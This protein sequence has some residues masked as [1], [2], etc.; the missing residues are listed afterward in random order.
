MYLGLLPPSHAWAEGQKEAH[1]LVPHLEPEEGPEEHRIVA[2]M[3]H[4]LGEVLG[5]H[6]T[7]LRLYLVAVPEEQSIAAMKTD[8]VVVLEVAQSLR[9]V[10]YPE[11]VLEALNSWILQPIGLDRSGGCICS[12]SHRPGFGMMLVSALDVV[13]DHYSPLS[14]SRN[15]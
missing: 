10:S 8:Q 5:E 4:V 14:C 6:H 3:I 12:S 9:P 1:I 15:T 11:A 7:A 2:T 13:Q